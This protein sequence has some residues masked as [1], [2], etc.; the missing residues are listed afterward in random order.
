MNDNSDKPERPPTPQERHARDGEAARMLVH[1]FGEFVQA[2]NVPLEMHAAVPAE[3]FLDW[4]KE[5]LDL[6][7]IDQVVEV[8]STLGVSPLVW[9][10]LHA[11]A[12]TGRGVPAVANVW[13]QVALA[14]R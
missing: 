6:M 1:F 9:D 5:R 14:G 7:P 4:L 11:A 2:Q 8:R 12:G 10:G 3:V 13:P